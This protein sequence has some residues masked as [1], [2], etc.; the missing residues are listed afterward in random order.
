MARNFKELRQSMSPE[1]QEASAN[2]AKKLKAEMPLFE[3]RQAQGL[4]QASIA[5]ILDVRQPTIA[6]MERNVDMYIS[7]L[8]NYITAMGGTLNITAAFPEGVVTIGNFTD[9]QRKGIARRVKIRI[10]HSSKRPNDNV[11]VSARVIASAA[12]KAVIA[13]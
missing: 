2:L 7:T 6:K 10:S 1:S 9:I 5:G 13:R 12:K 8:R 3:L 4:S 11:M